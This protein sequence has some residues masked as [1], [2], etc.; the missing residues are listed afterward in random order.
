M[1][2]R[3]T[4]CACCGAE[5]ANPRFCD[6][7]C[8]ATVNNRKSPKRKWRCR[9]CGGTERPSKCAAIC[10]GCRRS[11]PRKSAA[12]YRSMRK[13]FRGRRLASG[14]CWTCGGKKERSDRTYC[15]VCLKS[16]ATAAAERV[17]SLKERGLC[18]NCE[19]PSGGKALCSPCAANTLDKHLMRSYGITLKQFNDLSSAQKH[20]CA[21]CRRKPVEKPG[22]RLHVDHDHVTSRVRGLLCGQC[23]RSLGGFMDDQELLRR[24]IEYLRK[25][26]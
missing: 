24:A 10:L 26:S 11:R 1:S 17:A 18:R 19:K 4:K 15:G 3:L 16:R 13:A 14:L 9:R 7:S 20:R 12:D 21:I 8:A 22:E 25:H 2:S 23:N 6:R 5:T